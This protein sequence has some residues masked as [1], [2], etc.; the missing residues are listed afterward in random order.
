MFLQLCDKK[1]INTA[2][3][4]L[5][6]DP[7]L[8]V[9]STSTLKFSMIVNH[10]QSF[11]PF[12]SCSAFLASPLQLVWTWGVFVDRTLALEIS[13]SCSH[14][15]TTFP[16]PCKQLCC[17]RIYCISVI[18]HKGTD[19]YLIGQCGTSIHPLPSAYPRSRR[20]P[21]QPSPQRPFPAPPGGSQGVPRS[22]MTCNSS[23]VFWI[24][25]GASSQLDM[26]EKTSK[27]KQP[28]GILNRCLNHL[29]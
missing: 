16:L 18:L 12:C 6:S 11:S 15:Q 2:V 17:P 19:I 25:P 26:R 5:I 14:M 13:I 22:D 10:S 28:G 8:Y 1:F 21:R 4:V 24:C 9:L 20:K 27:G 29:S 23:S 7:S 3:S